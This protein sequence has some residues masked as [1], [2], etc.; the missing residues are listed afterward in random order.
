MG[1]VLSIPDYD[2]WMDIYRRFRK[3]GFMKNISE[4][5]MDLDEDVFPIEFEIDMG[6]IFELVN[7]PI[8][9]PFRKKLDSGL[10]KCLKEV[11]E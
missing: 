7:S 5:E 8:V 9:A 3:A 11:I 6:P 1:V 2:S 10:T 4:E